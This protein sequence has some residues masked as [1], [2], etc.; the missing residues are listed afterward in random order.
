[1]A[2]FTKPRKIIWNKKH[3]LLLLLCQEDNMVSEMLS[4]IFPCDIQ[5][6]LTQWHDHN[7]PWD[8]IS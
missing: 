7:Q 6:L 8:H 2:T 5:G 1:M 4:G 3:D